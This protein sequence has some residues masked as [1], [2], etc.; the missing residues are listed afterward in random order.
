MT[1]AR[2][3]SR[4]RSARARVEYIAFRVDTQQ[5]RVTLDKNGHPRVGKAKAP[6]SPRRRS[7][8]GLKRSGT[9]GRPTII[10]TNFSLKRVG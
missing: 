5:R 10:V 4:Y 6:P 1:A 3:L 8:R 2:V 9:V 7:D